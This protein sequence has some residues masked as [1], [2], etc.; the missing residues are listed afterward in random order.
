MN[1]DVV[2]E[3]SKE[4]GELS[5]FHKDLLDHVIKLVTMRRTQMS[6]SYEDWDNQEIIY[7]GE[8]QPDK[9][10]V[11]MTKRD[12]PVKMVVPTTF[13]QVMTFA[14]FLFMLFTQNRSFYELL[15]KGDEDY[16]KKYR[17]SEK[18][19]ERDTRANQWNMLLFQHLLA[20][21]RFGMGVLECSW[22]R[23]LSRIYVP[24]EPTVINIAGVESEVQAGSEWGGVGGKEGKL[25]GG[26]R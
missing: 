26:G 13:A 18:V 15:P 17:D 21:A 1:Q 23:K 7:K 11:E 8:R 24:T 20:T 6:K 25:G 9:T 10:D 2:D 16:G 3:L 4:S 14:S 19:L 5:D 12:K 22:T